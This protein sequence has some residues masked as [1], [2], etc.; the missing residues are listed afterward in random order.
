MTTRRLT[1][2]K[3]ATRSC[4]SPASSTCAIGGPSVDAKEPRRSVYTKVLRNTHDPLLDVFDVPETF[5]STARRNVTTTPTQALLMLNS[6][7]M[8]QQAQAFAARLLR[9]AGTDDGRIDLAF[10]LAFGRAATAQQKEQVARSSRSRRS[11][12]RPA[13]IG[14]ARCWR[15]CAW[16]C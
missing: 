2:S 10:R 5:T 3:S 15:R 11:G 16:C 4:R 12:C 9:E 14:S 8:Q 1:P 13:R 6:P 7:F